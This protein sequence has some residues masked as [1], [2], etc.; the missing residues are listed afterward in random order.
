MLK[1]ILL[2]LIAAFVWLA[3]KRSRPPAGGPQEVER[4][5]E[6]PAETMVACAHCGVHLPEAEA[7]AQGAAFYCCPAH[8]AA[9]PRGR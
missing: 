4:R 1:W 3:W 5:A 8:R 9:G 7:L 6:R 2:G